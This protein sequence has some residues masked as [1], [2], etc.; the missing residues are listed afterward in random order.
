MQGHG[1]H[2]A[3]CAGLIALGVGA[4]AAGLGALKL[5]AAAGCMLMMGAMVW[6][7]LRGGT[8]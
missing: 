5:V 6:M 7:M 3:I 2:L 1:K 8:S 4:A